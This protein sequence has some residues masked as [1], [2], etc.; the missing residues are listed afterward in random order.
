MPLHLTRRSWLGAGMA[1]AI[2]PAARAQPAW[3]ARP[4]K[5]IV[6]FPPGSS[7]DVVARLI[8][9]PLAASLGQPVVVD[10]KPGAG[11]NIGTAVAAKAAPDGY[12]WLLTIQGPLVTAPL[13][14]RKL[15][16]DPRRELVPVSLVA[17]S[18]NVLVV[19]AKL[20]AGTLAEFEQLA[21]RRKGELN[22][23]SVGNGSA[24]HLAMAWFQARAGL[25]LV[26]VPYPGFPQVVNAM[27]IGEVQA[28][29][30]VPGTAMPHVR[31]GRLRALGVTTPG[32][33]GSLP[34]LPTFAEQ[35]HA[36]FEAVSWQAVMAPANTPPAC[37][38]RMTAEITRIVRGDT[39]RTRLLGQYFT[40]AGTSPEA[41][42]GL[43]DTERDRWSKVIRAAGVRA[44]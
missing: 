30:M 37:I 39:F 36:G 19:D 14:S 12:T 31:S 35:G 28:A 2:V 42:R 4:L 8:A 9:E 24:S 40:A 17:T 33:V 25:D 43:I 20:G 44:E 7:P 16:Y 34:D 26:H 32:R 15:P 11:G 3:P 29:F 10:N 27:L 41:L 5:L 13:L 22:Y 38:A 6:P 23:A 18:P 21:R 1:A